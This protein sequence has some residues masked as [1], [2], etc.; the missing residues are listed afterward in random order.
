MSP[1]VWRAT[2]AL[3]GS[4]DIN[5]MEFEHM[6]VKFDGLNTRLHP[7]ALNRSRPHP[8]YVPVCS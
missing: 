6:L 8:G 5:A 1:G 7:A 4:H 2:T 3:H